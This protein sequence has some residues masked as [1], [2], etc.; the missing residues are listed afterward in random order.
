[1]YN[2]LLKV[3]VILFVPIDMLILKLLGNILGVKVKYPSFIPSAKDNGGYG[4]SVIKYY[5]NSDYKGKLI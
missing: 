2:L 5:I 1:M 3:I 4:G